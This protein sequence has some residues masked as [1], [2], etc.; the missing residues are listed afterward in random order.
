MKFDQLSIERNPETKDI[1]VAYSPRTGPGESIELSLEAAAK[2]AELLPL[3]CS[4]LKPR[5]IM[6]RWVPY[7]SAV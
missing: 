1:L 6:E 2:L 4:S 3:V 5:S 7:D